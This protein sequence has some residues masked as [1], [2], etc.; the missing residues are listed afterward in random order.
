MLSLDLRQILPPKMLF[1]VRQKGQISY[2]ILPQILKFTNFGTNQYFRHDSQFSLFRQFFIKNEILW[3][4]CNVKK[5][6]IWHRDTFTQNTVQLITNS[7]NGHVRYPSPS[8]IPPKFRLVSCSL[9]CC[10]QTDGHWL[11]MR[12]LSGIFLV[13]SQSCL[14]TNPNAITPISTIY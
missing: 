9:E 3:S 8:E 7:R 10:Q 13:V 6:V 11:P 12:S 5:H 1:F 4:L 2:K 14:T